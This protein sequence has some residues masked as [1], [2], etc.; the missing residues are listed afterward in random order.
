MAVYADGV[1]KF[2]SSKFT[3]LATLIS[4]KING[5][6]GMIDT[7]GKVFTIKIPGKVGKTATI[8][9]NAASI[10]TAIVNA[11]GFAVLTVA[12]KPATGTFLNYICE[13]VIGT[14]GVSS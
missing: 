10:G 8:F 13:D 2:A 3:P 6:K 11:D 1:L 4:R 7:A 14:I 9:G 12:T 5:P